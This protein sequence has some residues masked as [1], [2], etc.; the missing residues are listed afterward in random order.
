[1]SSLHPYAHHEMTQMT[2]GLVPVSSLMDTELSE[3]TQRM[4]PSANIKKH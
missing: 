2:Q 3:E 1:M 4:N